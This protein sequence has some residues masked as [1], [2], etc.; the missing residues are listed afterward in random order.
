[1]KDTIT[2]FYLNSCPYPLSYEDRWRERILKVVGDL[3]FMKVLKN[4]IKLAFWGIIGYLIYQ[5]WGLNGVLILVAFLL[6]L[7][8]ITFE[9]QIKNS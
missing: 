2:N 7:N 4:I 3:T 6:F 9:E 5:A 8:I 1:M